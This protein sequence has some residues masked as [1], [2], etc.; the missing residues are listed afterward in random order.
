MTSTRSTVRS[1][2]Q[3]SWLRRFAVRRPLTAF[4]VVGMSLGYTLALVWGLFRIRRGSFDC[5]K[6]QLPGPFFG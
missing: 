4:L 6:G 2:T 3:D 1:P 5:P